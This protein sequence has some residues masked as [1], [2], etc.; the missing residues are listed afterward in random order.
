LWANTRLLSVHD[1]LPAAPVDVERSSVPAREFRRCFNGFAD[2]KVFRARCRARP[3]GSD[4]GMKADKETTMKKITTYL[5]FDGNAEQAVELYTSIFPSS[6]VTHVARWREGGPVPEGT[7]MNIAFELD[8]QPFI[9]LNGGP[10][11][12]F[13]PAI[14]LFVP[15]ASQDEVDR[16]WSRFLAAGGV[17]GSC[18]WLEDCFGLSWQIVPTKLVDLMSDPDPARAGRVAKT[19]MTMQKIDV[20]A[21]ERAHAG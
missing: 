15:C 20:T 7:V 2:S 11:F 3:V 6:R 5:W 17:A 18:G 21:L 4:R 13:T 12:K 8:G 19:L 10:Q 14:S 9:A 1:L 16:I